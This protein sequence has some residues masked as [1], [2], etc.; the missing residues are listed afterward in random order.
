MSLKYF[1]ILNLFFMLSLLIKLS[2]SEILVKAENKIN[3]YCEKNTYYIIVNVTFS[4]EPKYKIYYF[5]LYLTSPENLNFKCI[6]D[7]PKNQIYC[8]RSYIGK[9]YFISINKYIQFPDNFPE[10]DNIEWDH[11]TFEQNIYN[12]KLAVEQNCNNENIFN[13]IN[14]NLENSDLEGNISSIESDKCKYGLINNGMNI[15]YSF[16][17]NL[18]FKIVIENNDDIE[19]MQEIFVPL[20]TKEGKEKIDS[21]IDIQNN[22]IHFAICKSNENI[23]K[24]SFSKFILNCELPILNNT[25]LNNVFYISSFFDKLYI[26]QKEE[27]KLISIYLYINNKENSKQYLSLSDKNEEILCPNQPLF[28]ISNK[29]YITMGDYYNNNNYNFLI[30]GTLSNGYNLLQNGT[31]IKLKETNEDINFRLIIEDNFLESKIN[32]K[33]IIPKGSK[34][35]MKNQANIKCIGNLDDISDSNKNIDITLDWHLVENNNFNNL[36]ISWPK[37]YDKSTEANIYYYKLT[38][39]SI[40]DLNFSCDTNIFDF[41]IYISELNYKQILSFDLPLIMPKNSY[42]KCD[43]Y[44]SSILLC[45]LDLKYQNLREG[46]K[47]IFPPYGSEYD[48]YDNNGNKIIFNMNNEEKDI[49]IVLHEKCGDYS[50]VES[51][52]GKNIKLKNIYIYIVIIVIAFIILG[53]T[54]LLIYKIRKRIKYGIKAV[55]TLEGKDIL[56]S[57]YRRK[58]I[59]K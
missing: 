31:V 45:S 35:N 59:Q 42:A 11:D 8:F 39:L 54:I 14:L 38:G 40:K 58:I 49:Y 50:V 19:L 13:K 29:D 16:N 55:N 56:V 23:N 48:I 57:T 33:C 9:P 15:I 5:T 32:V 24:N 51:Y 41:F 7:Y 36:I 46:D 26:K 44:N 4:E 20:I 25:L 34:Y 17:I 30:T 10:L 53:I 22:D 6:L 52:R 3:F 43:I 1:P 27:I 2:I 37:T 28:Y 18:S 21:N 12:K 47:I